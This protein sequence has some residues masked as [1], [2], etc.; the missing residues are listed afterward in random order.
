MMTN[1][2]TGFLLAT[3]T[4]STSAQI[5]APVI[6]E[7]M[8]NNSD[9]LS[10]GDGS[11]P[12]WI[13]IH[14]SSAADLVLTGWHLT[15]D[16]E[17]LTKWTFPLNT[18]LTSGARL[19][20]YASNG[21]PVGPELHANF[22]LSEGGEYLALIK[23]DGTI[24]QEFSPTFPQQYSDVSY[25]LTPGQESYKYFQTPTPGEANND[26][27]LG[28]VKDTTFSHKRG[29]YEAPFQLEVTTATPG[30]SIR[31]TTDGTPPGPSSAEVTPPSPGESPVLTLTIDSNT[32]VRA[33]AEKSGFES[34]NTDTQTYLFADE[35]VS[36]SNMSPIITGNGAWGSQMRDALLEIPSISLVTQE[37]VPTTPIMSPPEIPVSI[38]MFFPDGR[39]GFQ[40][41]AGIER[42]GGQYTLYPKNALR[43]SFKSKYGPKRL[44]FDLFSETEYGGETAVDSFDQILLRNGSHDSIFSRHYTHSR[45]VYVRNRYFFDRQLEEGH[46]SMR[47]RFVHVYLNGEYYGQ[48]HLMERPNADFMATHLGGEEEDYDIMKGR[49]GIFVSQG[50]KT[51]W[52]HMVANKGNY[53]VVKDYMD[54]D[55]YI[56]YMLL[57]FYGGNEHDWY[58]QHNWVAGRKREPG[59]KFKFFM[60]DNDFLNRRGG[61]AGAGSTANTTDNG[62]PGNMIGAL[63]LHDEFNIRMADRAQKHFF[64]GGMLSPERVQEDFTDLSESISRTVIPE[65][66]RW[67]EVARDFEA[68]NGLYTPDLFQNYVDW[69]VDV[70]AP[71]RSDVVIGQMRSAGMFPDV[72]APVFNQHGG[73]VTP[74]FGLAI[75]NNTGGIYYTVDGSDPRL[76]GGGINPTALQFP[77][78]SKSFTSIEAG[79]DWKFYDGGD[80]GTAWRAPGFD[81]SAWDSGAAPIG[82]GGIT[83]T[84]LN[85]IINWDRHMTFYCRKTFDITNVS[86]ISE[87]SFQIHA[88]G[89]AV[90]FINGVEAVRDNMPEGVIGFDTGS[91]NDGVEGVFDTYTLD[92][93]LLVEG[94]NFIAVEVHNQRPGSGDMVFDL[95]LTGS[96]PLSI[97]NTTTVR[98][99]SLEG[100]TWSALNEATFLA[101][102]PATPKKLVISKIHYHPSGP[103]GELS[104]YIELLNI[105]D[106]DVDLAGV[107]F[108]QGISF[109]FGDD[110]TLTPGQRVVL[111]ADAAAF[112]SAFGDSATILGT[113][114]SRL[115]NGGE[116]LTLRAADGSLL[117][118]VRFDD[119]APWPGEADGLG[120]SL[121]LVSPNSA[122]DHALAQNWRASLDSGGN[123]GGSDS[124]PFTGNPDTDLFSYALGDPNGVIIRTIDGLPVLELPRIL[125]ADDVSVRVEVSSD[126][127]TWQDSE[128]IL[129]NQSARNGNSIITQWSLAPE[130]EDQKYARVIVTQNQ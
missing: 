37:D 93:G 118:A 29:F 122:P 116:Q 90:V 13:E 51:A 104:E 96:R 60:W 45:A 28:F 91:I 113:Y 87:A 123:P 4:L 125:G 112:T 67:T 130:L 54:I 64:N 115:D 81:D 30:A 50:E 8:A 68:A 94:V 107:A 34:T 44:K 19:L 89:G 39:D 59:G 103:Q 10:L 70:N 32:I 66:A 74:G 105:S 75:T 21:A 22:K 95:S 9:T 12:D 26:S 71:T 76:V 49:S 110:T 27:V 61:N 117:H 40:V 124:V 78:S 18:S 72:D 114:P 84:T 101:G 38:E 33:V 53:E 62:G 85:S 111:V 128:A 109:S 100:T 15:D 23:P 52:D 47:G 57:N 14:N 36:H 42:F 77:G 129:L 98:A 119:Q 24:H 120:Y 82:F 58:P 102:V 106:Q 121:V 1:F 43:V 35:V 7:F 25:G 127:K 48:F 83:G 65:I 99:R 126:L 69:I 31:Y 55:S 86:T 2:L 97:D 20:V 5:N 16:L 79:S 6:S 11:A 46:L 17:D 108:T 92:P 41:D 73:R 56:D 63:K 3:F 88:D 80:L